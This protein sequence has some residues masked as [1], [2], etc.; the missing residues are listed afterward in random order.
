MKKSN[1]VLKCIIFLLLGIFIFQVISYIFVPKWIDPIDPATARLK[2]YYNEKPNTID[3]IF[4]GNSETSRGYSPITVWQK[5]GITSYNYGSSFQTTQIA[6]YKLK[7]CLKYQ[8]PKIILLE[9]NSFFEIA[10]TEEA[11]RKVLNN[12]KLD[13]VTLNAILDKNVDL[14]NRLSYVLPLLRFHSRWNQLETND[15]KISLEKEFQ[16]VQY[17]GMPVIV[18]KSAYN[19]DKDYMREKGKKE[20]IPEKNLN[21]IEKIVKCCEDKKIKLVMVEIPTPNVWSLAKNKAIIELANNYGIDFIDFN[22]MQNQIGLDWS[23]DTYDA[24]GHMNV[25]GAEKVSSY[26]GQVLSEKYNLEDHRNN[27]E[28]ADDWNETARRYEERKLELEKSIINNKK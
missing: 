5:Y 26:I 19:G 15:F 27:K 9:T 24:G 13:N 20:K 14:D 28:I 12:L 10:S 1:K 17:K 8:N 4:V 3:V 23:N 22:L 7:E 6:Y 18:K 11:Y 16:T 21:Y 2:E 25:Y